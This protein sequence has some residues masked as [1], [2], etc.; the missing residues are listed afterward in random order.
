MPS[1]ETDRRDQ[2]ER[3]RMAD[4]ALHAD[5]EGRRR[6]VDRADEPPPVSH[7][8]KSRDLPGIRTDKPL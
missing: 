8:D 7:G 3:G 2:R 1:N 4:A 5:R 6:L